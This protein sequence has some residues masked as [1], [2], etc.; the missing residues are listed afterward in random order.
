VI[1]AFIRRA[2]H[3]GMSHGAHYQGNRCIISV[4]YCLLADEKS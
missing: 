2:R 1:R 3:G 4:H